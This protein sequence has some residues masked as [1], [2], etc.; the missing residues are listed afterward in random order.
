V[1][2]EYSTDFGVE[3]KSSTETDVTDLTTADALVDEAPVLT[4]NSA[5]CLNV[6]FTAEQEGFLDGRIYQIVLPSATTYSN[7]AGPL[8]DDI[9]IR[10]AGLRDFRVP[11]VEDK[12]FD[13]RSSQLQIWLPHGLGEG[14]N[15]TDFPMKIVRAST[16]QDV[17]LSSNCLVV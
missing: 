17:S 2:E 12:S 8:A 3:E 1:G 14:L 11:F 6:S 7:Q 5:R 10:F 4:G 15:I 16:G 13:V 9:T